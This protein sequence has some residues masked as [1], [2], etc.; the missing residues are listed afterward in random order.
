MEGVLSGGGFVHAPYIYIYICIGTMS[1]GSYVW[2]G[3]CRRVFCPC[4]EV[5]G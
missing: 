1:R 3:F 2:R 5:V 4:T